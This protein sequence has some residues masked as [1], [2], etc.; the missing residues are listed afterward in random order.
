MIELEYEMT[1]AENI[2]GP[3]GPTAGSPLGERLCW[4]VVSG[5]LRGPRI[6][7]SL[8]MPGMDWMRLGI[9]GVR[10]PISGHSS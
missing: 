9:D 3:L 10:S 8:A 7:A 6:D 2:G 5:R 1:Y 4:Q